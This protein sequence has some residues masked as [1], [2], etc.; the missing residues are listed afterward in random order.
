MSGKNILKP[1][2]HCNAPCKMKKIYI[3]SKTWS[4]GNTEL[5]VLMKNY[6]WPFFDP[7]D[8]GGCDGLRVRSWA[9][10]IE[11]QLRIMNMLFRRLKNQTGLSFGAFCNVLHI[12]ESRSGPSLLIES[13]DSMISLPCSYN[14]IICGKITA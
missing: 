8:L 3:K 10:W 9:C 2:G 6:K 5:C 14:Y 4:C 13:T 11:N 7:P 1:S 12:W